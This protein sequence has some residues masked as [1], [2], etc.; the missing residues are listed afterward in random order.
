KMYSSN[1]YRLLML[2]AITSG[3]EGFEYKITDQVYFDVKIGDEYAGRIIL[4]LFGDVAPKTCENFKQIAT[5]G[6]NGK[7]YAGTRFHTAIE[8]IMIQGGDIENDDG[9]GSLSIY[10]KYFEDENFGI[11]P[12]SS[13]LLMMA[14]NGPN[15]NGCE[16]LITTLPMPWLEGKNVVFGKVLKG[17]DV[18]HIIEHLKTDINDRILENVVIEKCGLLEAAPFFEAAKNY[19]LTFWAW[20]KAGWFPLSFSFAILGFFQYILMQLNKYKI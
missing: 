6:V 18:V 3:L 2:L 20:I 4:G 7:T 1:S 12:D 9:T 19:E 15:T 11:P 16:F 5:K 17:N 10:G 13:G 8:R 14:N